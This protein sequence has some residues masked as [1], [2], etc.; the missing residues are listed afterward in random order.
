MINFYLPNFYEQNFR[1]LNTFFI[2]NI[3]DNPEWFY[4]NIHIGAVY[5]TFPGV[6]WN[7]GRVMIGDVTINDICETISH[8]YSL[9][10]PIRF[11]YTNSLIQDDHLYDNYANI[12]T[13][14]AQNGQNEILV[15]SSILEN[16]LRQ[17]YPNYKFISST[18]KCLFDKQEIIDESQKYYLTVLDYRKNNNINFLSSL[19]NPDK[20][21]LLI[22]AYCSPNCVCREEHYRQ[23]SASQLSGSGEDIINCK[24]KKDNFFDTLNFSSVIKIDDLYSTYAGIG[25]KHFKIE[26]RTNHI[27][28]VLE[29]Y[30]YYMVKP[31]FKDKIRYEVLKSII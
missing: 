24:I 21:E 13:G 29:S 19:G 26:G 2:K 3:Q 15:N 16:Y 14:L 8:Y 12:I 9:N 6:I 10:T 28:D 5:G 1:I 17:E 22:N 30:L 4:E 27:I 31:E 11:T 7:G 25:F 23:L 20:Y 18:T